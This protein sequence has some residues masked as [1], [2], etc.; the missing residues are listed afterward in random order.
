MKS[1]PV[2]TAD[3][4]KLR[5]QYTKD[6]VTWGLH[7][8]T[9][10]IFSDEKKFNLDGPDGFAHYWH[11][12]RKKPRV[13]STRQ[14][15]GTSVMVWGAMSCIQPSNVVFI[16][17]RQASKPYCEVLKDGLL[18]FAEGSMGDTYIFQQD[19]A[20]THRSVHTTD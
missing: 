10:V 7:E 17:D 15:G 20:S 18:E 3:H 6:H 14:Q 8:W 13:F 11:D 19:N 1:V 2:M 12:I 5:Y 9:E 16:N 4:K